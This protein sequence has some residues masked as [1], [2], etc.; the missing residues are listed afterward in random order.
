[1]WAQ[2]SG[3]PKPLLEDKWAVPGRARPRRADPA[4]SVTGGSEPFSWARDAPPWG[5]YS[6]DD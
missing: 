1:M 4:S 2:M 5:V 3:P 6:N